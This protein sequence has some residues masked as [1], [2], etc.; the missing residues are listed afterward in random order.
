MVK[1]LESGLTVLGNCTVLPVTEWFGMEETLKIMSFSSFS[2]FLFPQL[3]KS[4]VRGICLDKGLQDALVGVMDSRL[5]SAGATSQ[6]EEDGQSL[7][8]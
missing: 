8:S 1:D 2:Y 3:T 5:M 4:S 7:G 6:K